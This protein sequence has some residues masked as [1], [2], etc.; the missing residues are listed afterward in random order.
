MIFEKKKDKELIES[1][2]EKEKAMD[3]LDKREKER[4]KKEFQQNRVYLEYIMNQK[5]EA[6]IWMDKIAQDEAEHEYKKEQEKWNKEDQKRIELLKDVYKE[7]EKALIYQKKI[8]ED[9]K[10]AITQER[11]KL[12]KEIGEYYDKLE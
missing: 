12:D 1:M 3:L 5:K 6:E 10:N 9:E 8:K 4:K 11:S 2:V 7:R